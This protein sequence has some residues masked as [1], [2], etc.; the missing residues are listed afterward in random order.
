MNTKSNA[1]YEHNVQDK[2]SKR[3]FEV[4]LTLLSL[5]ASLPTFI[6]LIWVMIYAEISIYLILL[7]ILLASVLLIFCNS[8]IH[9]KSSYQFRS[10]SN[11]LDAMVQGDYS[12]RARTTEKD[13]ALNE[14]VGAINSLAIR[15]NKQRIESVESQLLL[16]T[17]INHID[18]AIIALNDTNEM[19]L[20]NPA[21]KA[22]LEQSNS[23]SGSKSEQFLAQF[24]QSEVIE[25]GQSQIMPLS[26]DDQQRKYHVHL[27]EYREQGKQQKL[28]FITDV[29]N[30]LRSEERKA[31]Q[32]LVRVIS[33]EINNSLAP[34]N[35]ISQSLHRLLVKQDQISEYKDHL[36]EG[37][38]VIAQ[39]SS[40]LRDFVNSYK[41]IA[42]L[43]EPI[44][45][46]TSIVELVSKVTALYKQENI[47]I[48]TTTD[49]SLLID[50]VQFEQVLINLIKNAVEANKNE[51]G[52]GRVAINWQQQGHLFKLAIIDN[53]T[54]VSN[55]DNLF[56]P[57]YTTKA[58]GSG[59]GLVL[60][61]QIIDAH[62]GHLML[63]NRENTKGCIATIE[64]T[65]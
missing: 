24:V 32:A 33:H 11:L 37:V 23:A 30:M 64:L 14:L 15:L 42:S 29:S 50:I 10:L 25:S 49:M 38:S 39:R 52:D 35:S 58:K 18:V 1:S 6:L 27:E 17:V 12:L 2:K 41:Q 21:A 59:I 28:L 22:L 47:D 26:F 5:L 44:K 4:Q 57:F 54:G 34:I 13:D 60:C 19:V 3:S 40:N 61:R 55:P 62:G 46:K 43:P 51:G 65:L 8:K 9:Q 20:T 63:S 45:Q 16:N 53:G 56:V 7:A 48:E 36:I 31:W